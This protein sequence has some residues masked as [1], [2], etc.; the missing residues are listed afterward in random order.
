M[1]SD[2]SV[3]LVSLDHAVFLCPT[4]SLSVLILYICLGFSVFL[5]FCL[6]CFSVT[7]RVAESLQPVCTTPTTHMMLWM[8]CDLESYQA[9][10]VSSQTRVCSGRRNV[11][12]GEVGWGGGCRRKVIKEME[13][14]W[15]KRN[16]NTLL[17]LDHQSIPYLTVHLEY[18]FITHTKPPKYPFILHTILSK[19]HVSFH[20]TEKTIR[21][22]LHIHKTIQES[23]PVTQNYSSILS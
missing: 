1:S 7:L 2:L 8:W 10:L 16:V 22:N 17:L 21:V 6:S 12:G 18:P 15:E 4:V 9:S 14:D 23:L 13:R 20:Y 19:T 3:S 5:S 11:G